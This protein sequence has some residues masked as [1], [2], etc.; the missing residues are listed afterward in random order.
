ML[1]ISK[2]IQL[3]QQSSKSRSIQLRLPSA[4][5]AYDRFKSTCPVSTNVSDEAPSK[6]TTLVE[7]PALPYLG[8]L[9][10][11]WS[12]VPKFDPS[13]SYDFWKE[14]RREYGD[15]YSMGIPGLGKGRD[16]TFYVINDPNEMLK[17]IRQEKTSS[18][19]YPRGIIETEWPLIRYF[20]EQG[21]MLGNGKSG[22]GTPSYD[23][24]G[25]FGRGETW[26]RLRTFLQTDLLSP[27]SAKRYISCM[28]KAAQ[29][30]SQAAPSSVDDL[31]NYLNQCA[32]DMF[33]SL[34]YG[35][36]TNTANIKHAKPENV[37]F[38]NDAVEGMSK[39]VFQISQPYETIMGYMLGMKTS[40]YK[41]MCK[42]WDRISKASNL[43]YKGFRERFENDYEGLT[44]L[45]K[46]SYIAHAIVRQKESSDGFTEEELSE[47]AK[48]IV[49]R[50]TIRLPA[51]ASNCLYVNR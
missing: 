33:H 29:I 18:L 3:V 42:A 44:D 40:T 48:V 41:E 6:K 5:V 11:Q 39:M 46:D 14:V 20:H 22:D 38:C 9:V 15:F 23:E 32:F 4:T 8:S 43:K 21:S 27:Q 25:F 30:A 45:E 12:K 35:E 17:V 2:S 36:L 51:R 50:M 1:S 37:A 26:K 49:D 7:V 10:P 47:V 16:G 28:V 24:D 19:P 34:M 13:K 31:N